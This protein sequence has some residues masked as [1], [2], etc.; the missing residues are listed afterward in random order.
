M[1]DLG[2]ANDT[3]DLIIKDLDLVLIDGIDQ[4][5]QNL[6]ITLRFFLGEWYLDTTVGIPYYQYFFIK[7]PN[8]IQ[9]DSFLMNAIYDTPGVTNI[10]AYASKYSAP[11]REYSVE[12][13]A[14]TI[15]G[16]TEIEVT[17]P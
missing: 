8:Q 12:F 16:D 2:L 4:I 11:G 17:L 5:A 3:H 14:S 7:N 15:A 6:N 10:T 1:I 13:T 9:V